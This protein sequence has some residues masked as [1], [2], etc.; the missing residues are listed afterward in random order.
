[1]SGSEPLL[2]SKSKVG[3]GPGCLPN[4]ELSLLCG[5]L[6]LGHS[7][8]GRE[9]VLV[10]ESQ[11]FAFLHSDA[12]VFSQALFVQIGVPFLS[13]LFPSGVDQLQIQV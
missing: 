8:V 6:I 12:S 2:G 5:R 3:I 4:R 13:A 7:L 1:M 11:H 10:Q 9:V